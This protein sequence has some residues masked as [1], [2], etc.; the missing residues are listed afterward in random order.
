MLQSADYYPCS[1]DGRDD[2]T[3]FSA[4]TIRSP[5]VHAHCN[6][7]FNQVCRDAVGCE[8]QWLTQLILLCCSRNCSR[9]VRHVLP[10]QNQ[11]RDR[12]QG[13]AGIGRAVSKAVAD[14]CN[15]TYEQLKPEMSMLQRELTRSIP[16]SWQAF[17]CVIEC[18]FEA[19]F[20][21]LSGVERNH[22]TVV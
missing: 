3:C 9:Q 15:N 11:A 5:A 19:T 21:Q 18:A 22:L 17:T 4:A 16:L 13:T 12:H 7:L 8:P 6:N 20:R 1:W 10:L 2:L 14:Q